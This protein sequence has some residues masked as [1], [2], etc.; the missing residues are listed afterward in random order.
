V[1][2]SIDWISPIWASSVNVWYTVRSEIPGI[3]PEAT[4]NNESAV[5]WVLL[6][7]N[8]RNNN[9]RCGVTFRPAA[10]NATVSS[11]GERM[12]EDYRNECVF[13]MIENK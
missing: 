8:K 10:R 12:R 7:C 13:A 4:P 6:L 2:T 11:S 1:P 9:W 3:N 5:G